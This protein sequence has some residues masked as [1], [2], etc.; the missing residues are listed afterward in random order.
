MAFGFAYVRVN[1]NFKFLFLYFISFVLLTAF[2]V[3]FANGPTE[4]FGQFVMGKLV[5]CNVD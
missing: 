4:R 1:L 3:S 2:R 5:F